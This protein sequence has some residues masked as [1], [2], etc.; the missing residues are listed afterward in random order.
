MHESNHSMHTLFYLKTPPMI[1][2]SLPLSISFLAFL[3]L[4]IKLS[5]LSFIL[6][7]SFSVYP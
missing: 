5:V 7:A 2:I 6:L 3:K 4:L 1:S